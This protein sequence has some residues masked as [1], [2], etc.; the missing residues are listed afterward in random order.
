M[1]FSLNPLGITSPAS[2]A[3]VAS[4]YLAFS[5][6]V[7]I[8]NY[9]TPLADTSSLGAVSYPEAALGCLTESIGA[10][11]LLAAGV[12]T[13]LIYST[14]PPFFFIIMKQTTPTMTPMQTRAP[15]QIPMRV[16]RPRPPSV[17]AASI[18]KAILIAPSC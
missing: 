15:T 3:A 5:V 16:P 6:G 17:A 1:K 2:G 11:C 7:T 8:D 9:S 14:C 10:G 18:G 13:A 4:P 12:F